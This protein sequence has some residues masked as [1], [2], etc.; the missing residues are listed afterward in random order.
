MANDPQQRKHNPSGD[1]ES[2]RTKESYDEPES[3]NDDI[4]RRAPGQEGIRKP[5]ERHAPGREDEAEEKKRA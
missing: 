5:E 1:E 4:P 2:E 3:E